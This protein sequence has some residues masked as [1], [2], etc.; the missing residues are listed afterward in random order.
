VCSVG[1]LQISLGQ[2][3]ISL[4]GL[5]IWKAVREESSGAHNGAW[6]SLLVRHR[7]RSFCRV[8]TYN[9]TASRDAQAKVLLHA[10]LGQS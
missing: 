7:N 2:L 3:E 8:V 1:E 9:G 6:Q 5:E 4:E 10:Q